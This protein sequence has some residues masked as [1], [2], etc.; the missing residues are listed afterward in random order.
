MA[1]PV[2]WTGKSGRKYA[3]WFLD[4]KDGIK[5]EGGNYLFVKRT[6]TNQLVMLYAG[7][8]DSLKARLPNHER[9]ADARRAGATDIMAHTTPNGET[10][11]LAEEKDLIQQWNPVL[12]THHN[13]ASS[14]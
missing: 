11:R 1:D 3:Y 7:Q 14:R 6:A 5:D 13:Q 2:N 4:I 10:A 12:N 8:A 9:L